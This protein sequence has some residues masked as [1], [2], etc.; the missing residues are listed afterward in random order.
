MHKVVDGV[1]NPLQTSTLTTEKNRK[2]GS[3]FVEK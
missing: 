1:W 3:L 2:K